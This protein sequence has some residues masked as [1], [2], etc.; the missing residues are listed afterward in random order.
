MNSK[1]QSVLPSASPSLE[2]ALS[3]LFSSTH[4]F[5]ASPSTDSSSTHL[6]GNT[7]FSN[8]HLLLFTHL[9]HKTCYDPAQSRTC[10]HV[11]SVFRKTIILNR[12]LLLETLYATLQHSWFVLL[13]PIIS[14]LKQMSRCSRAPPQRRKTDQEIYNRH[15]PVYEQEEIHIFANSKASSSR[16]EH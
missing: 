2:P 9:N 14:L 4:L 1:L 11:S 10:S 3:F 6:G 7:H 8:T 5:S 15:N 12:I 13:Q 16:C